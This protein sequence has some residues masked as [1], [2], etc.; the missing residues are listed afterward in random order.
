MKL[1][2]IPAA[3]IFDMDGLIFDT[4]ALYQQAFLAASSARGY[5][6]PITLIQS[7]I[8]VPW[9]KSRLLILE[10]MGSDFPVDQYGEAVTDHF[11]LLATD[12]LR[13][14]PGVI[15]LLDVLDQLKL[16]R[17]IATS[18]SHST[19]QSH[20]SAHGL[21]GRFDA[22]I[23]HGDYAASK[24]SPDPFLTAAKRLSVE[25]ALC[26]ALEDSFN[27]VR[28]A[29]A[30]GMMTFMVPDLLSPTPEIHSLCTG[31]VSDLHAVC[32]LILT[33]SAAG[34]IE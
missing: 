8:G 29:S 23:A 15:E 24:P 10:Q 13:L 3:L 32:K 7:T 20:L 9:V 34:T 26:L 11:T 31:V 16:P 22:V 4:E 18:S 14:K 28:S 33:A 2:H 27:G 19:V 1:P 17:C 6:L 30:A 21:A 5:N 25:P 12:Q